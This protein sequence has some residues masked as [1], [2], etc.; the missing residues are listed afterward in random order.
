MVQNTV[1]R[2]LNSGFEDH[3]VS[4]A[5]GSTNAGLA[6]KQVS[7]LLAA[8]AQAGTWLVQLVDVN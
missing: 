4:V 2:T 7:S 3:F 8:G 6:E 5:V 1:G